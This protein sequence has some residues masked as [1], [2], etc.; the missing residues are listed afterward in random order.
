MWSFINPPKCYTLINKMYDPI[1]DMRKTRRGLNTWNKKT[2]GLLCEK[3]LE[4]II[5][6][7]ASH[8][9]ND[10]L[11]NTDVPYHAEIVQRLE[12]LRKMKRLKLDYPNHYKKLMKEESKEHQEK[13]QM[14][15][16][17]G[18]DK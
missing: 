13:I 5:N 7:V 11:P 1:K 12:L 2:D 14:A 6:M 10:D 9:D 4:N 8:I 17:D 16:E 15:K 3:D 18:I